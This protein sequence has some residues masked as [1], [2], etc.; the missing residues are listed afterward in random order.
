[1]VAIKPLTPVLT[2]VGILSVV[3]GYIRAY[4]GPFFIT[5]L[6]DAGYELEQIA[7]IEENLSVFWTVSA[8]A[9]IIAIIAVSYRYGAG[10]KLT[11]LSG[12]ILIILAYL[13]EMLGNLVGA[14]IC[15]IQTPKYPVFRFMLPEIV[16]SYGYIYL[17]LIGILAA[18]YVRELRNQK[19]STLT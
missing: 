10:Y 13:T 9:S 8:L 1:L 7:L 5:S 18:N 15:Q 2:F 4:T 6:H 11:K 19:A 17:V 16:F 12:F 3:F 14:A